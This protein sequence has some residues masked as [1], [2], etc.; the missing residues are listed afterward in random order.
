MN[1]IDLHTHSNY[2]DGTLSPTALLKLAADKKLAAV[3]L[4]D[5]DTIKGIPEALLAAVK[6]DVKLI[7]G[8]EIS[9][10]YKG[11]DIHML[12]LS[13]DY[14]QEAFCDALDL[15]AAERTK[16]NE[17]MV[18]NLQK[19]GI[20]I[21][22]ED[23]TCEEEDAVVT[24]A[25]FAKY[26]YS[27]HYVKSVKEAFLRYLNEDGPYY[28]P[29]SYITPENAIALIRSAGGIPVL[30]HP[31][32]YHLP[33]EELDL[34]VKRLKEHGLAAIEAI[35]SSNMGFDESDMRKLANKYELLIS[36]GSDFHGANKP[37]LEIGAGKGNLKIPMELLT[38][39]EEWKALHI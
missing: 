33:K 8:V 19:A 31:L 23:L 12:G 34:L 26:L 25:H 36:G 11:K 2:S 13:I 37:L 3:A 21:T 22:M 7:P 32:L 18:K 38:K 9:A 1:Y 30:A 6:N 5:H 17:K 16:R 39:L 35:Y 4:T 20:P 29:R 15:A 10:S 28:V 24:R 27:H 14:N